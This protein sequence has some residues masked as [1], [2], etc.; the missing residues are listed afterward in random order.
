MCFSSISF[1]YSSGIPNRHNIRLFVACFLS[2][3]GGFSDRCNRP[4]NCPD[5][6]LVHFFP[7]IFFSFPSP[8][9][10]TLASNL[11]I[12]FIRLS[13][14][15]KKKKHTHTHS[16]SL[17]KSLVTLKTQRS[18][19]PPLPHILITTHLHHLASSLSK[20]NLGLSLLALTAVAHQ[21][22]Q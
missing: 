18:I 9:P 22:K 4:S 5:M 20:P 17:S 7:S 10:I 21:L 16:L 12:F 6:F 1:S 3:S 2:Y 15:Q 19:F 13:P 11:F 14:S 8:K